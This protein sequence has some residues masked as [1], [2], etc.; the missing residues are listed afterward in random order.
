MSF[1]MSLNLSLKCQRFCYSPYCVNCIFESVNLFC[2]ILYD[3]KNVEKD[4]VSCY[5]SDYYFSC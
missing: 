3:E 4:Y 2:K 1:F 5:R